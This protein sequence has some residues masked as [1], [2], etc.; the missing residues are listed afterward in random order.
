VLTCE[1]QR[2]LDCQ[3]WIGP[4][5]HQVFRT[6]T[7]W[8][9]WCPSECENSLAPAN[10]GLTYQFLHF[11]VT[12]RCTLRTFPAPNCTGC[13]SGAAPSASRPLLAISCPRRPAD[14]KKSLSLKMSMMML[15]DVYIN[16]RARPMPHARINSWKIKYHHPAQHK[17][18]YLQIS[19]GRPQ[20]FT[21]GI[22]HTVVSIVFVKGRCQI[23]ANSSMWID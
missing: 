13:C 2:F 4:R 6:E 22:W 11:F 15:Y 5:W 10:P 14:I 7:P 21:F 8:V 23:L 1:F 17:H 3:T 19:C 18:K 20:I 16:E 12:C 9:W